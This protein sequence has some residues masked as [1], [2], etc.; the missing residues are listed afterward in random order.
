[1]VVAVIAV[2]LIGHI[3]VTMVS[4]TISL[5]DANCDA[6]DPDFD[7]FRDYHRI[8]AGVQSSGKCRQAQE[9]NN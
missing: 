1:V 7:V 2:S 8:A 5:T 4:M 6:A 9:W 3:E